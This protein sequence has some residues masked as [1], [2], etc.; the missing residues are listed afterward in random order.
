MADHLKRGVGGVTVLLEGLAD[1]ANVGSIIRNAAAF[2]ASLVVV[3]PKGASPFSRKAAR[4]SAG[5][6]FRTPIAIAKIHDAIGAL[7]VEARDVDI[8]ATT[9]RRD[10]LPLE[11]L[12]PAE[13]RAL[14]IGNEGHGVSD[15]VETSPTAAGPSPFRMKWTLST[16]QQHL[17]SHSMFCGRR[18]RPRTGPLKFRLSI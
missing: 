2:G 15:E 9:G 13:R 7:R 16:P 11:D 1:P 18:Q 8:V 10:A 17:R 4:A 6:I 12:P 3:D 5:H 14:V